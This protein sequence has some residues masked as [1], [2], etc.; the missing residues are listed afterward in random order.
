MINAFH[1][2]LPTVDLVGQRTRLAFD[3]PIL[4]SPAFRCA[5][6]VADGIFVELNHVPT[7]INL[8]SGLPDAEGRV[9]GCRL[10]PCS[11]RITAEGAHRSTSATR[12]RPGSSVEAT[13]T[14]T[15]Y[16]ASSSPTGTD[17]RIYSPHHLVAV[18][19]E[20]ND[21]HPLVLEDRT[22]AQL[23]ATLLASPRPSPLRR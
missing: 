6:G 5:G 12:T 21:R 9:V 18:D 8:F 3:P 11:L 1:E 14:A 20:M 4:F 7:G 22:P 10:E 19:D 17:L 15:A 23:F 13:R 2:H 16:C